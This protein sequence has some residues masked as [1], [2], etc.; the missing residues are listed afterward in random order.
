MGKKSDG[1]MNPFIEAKKKASGAKKGK[2]KGT[3]KPDGF[4][5]V[6]RY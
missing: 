6:V 5:G 3:K 1:E 4:R 2:P